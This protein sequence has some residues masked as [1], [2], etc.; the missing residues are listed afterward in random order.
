M[1]GRGVIGSNVF[2]VTGIC[3]TAGTRKLIVAEVIAALRKAAFRWSCIAAKPCRAHQSGWIAP[4][5]WIAPNIGIN[6]STRHEFIVPER[7]F[8]KGFS[9]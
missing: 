4:R 7:I 2:G 5:D 9:G 8:P 1:A 3:V 6:S